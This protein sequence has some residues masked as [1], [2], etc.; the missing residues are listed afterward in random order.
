[1][2]IIKVFISISFAGICIL[3]FSTNSYSLQ[4]ENNW[5]SGSLYIQEQETKESKCALN[6]FEGLAAVDG[7]PAT[8]SYVGCEIPGD[9]FGF[10][11][12]GGIRRVDS[13]DIYQG[14]YAVKDTK[15]AYGW[16]YR[17][18]VLED[19][20]SLWTAEGGDVL[21]ETEYLADQD[22]TK[23]YVYT[24]LDN[25]LYPTLVTGGVYYEYGINRSA[26][27]TKMYEVDHKIS[28]LKV[29]PDAKYVLAKSYDLDTNFD[30]VVKIDTIHDVI[31]H[32][33]DKQ[34]SDVDAIT[35]D[36]RYV[37]L[38]Y[39]IYDTQKC[40]DSSTTQKIC[41]SRAIDE[42]V[43]A[44]YGAYIAFIDG[45]YAKFSEDGDSIELNASVVMPDY[46]GMG[47]L[48][49]LNVS[50]YKLLDYLA[51]GDSYSSGEG[52]TGKKANGSS[53]Y[54]S[55]FGLG[56]GCHV[57]SRSY[58]FLLK[59]AW[60]ISDS[61]MKS[62]ACSGARVLPDMYGN[63]SNYLGQRRELV[64]KS[65]GDRQYMT[66]AALEDGTP[67]I[68]QQVEF[69][70][71]YRP[72]VVT[73]T[74]GGNDV[75][76]SDVIKYCADGYKVGGKIPIDETCA[77]ARDY[78]M[79]SDLYA[80]IDDQY[81][82]NLNLVKAIKDASPKSKIYVIGYP[83]FVSSGLLCNASSVVLNL[84]ERLMINGSVE[85]MNNVLKHVAKDAG[86]IYVDIED[87]LA[88]G[89][90]CEGS[91]YMT[92]PIGSFVHTGE[93]ASS[94]VYHP[95][96]D[97]QRK[98]FET[99]KEAI[100]NPRGTQLKELGVGILSHKKIV[101]ENVAPP[102]V[103][104]KGVTMLSIPEG[105]FQKGSKVK[106]EMY[107]EVTLLGEYVSTDQSGP[108]SVEVVIP[109][110]VE[111]GYH[112]LAITGEG[113]NGTSYQIQQFIEVTEDSLFDQSRPEYVSEPKPLSGTE[114]RSR[115]TIS[116][117]SLDSQG[118]K[119]KLIV[120]NQPSSKELFDSSAT[121]NEDSHSFGNWDVHKVYKYALIVLMFA[122]IMLGWVYAKR[123]KTKDT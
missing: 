43:R 100:D 89:R 121:P 45:R 62:V 107:S 96:A 6:R 92:G 31:G 103:S 17:K 80:Y 50:T 36:G 42:V 105:I 85:R 86:I 104:K 15:F 5:I 48:K 78:D 9:R 94:N 3:F 95:N 49:T 47:Q 7:A 34:R 109:G 2:K 71:K 41:Q 63:A 4:A 64:G 102:V 52:D 57:S 51:L 23:I 19:N 24:D 122:L 21:V 69:V 14:V 116:S 18:I 37:L 46:L 74:G 113:D 44:H 67:G 91:R 76:F 28:S 26:P 16:Q 88:G 123:K 8:S 75:G 30:E 118:N 98:M 112:L 97:G 58:P 87:S 60:G 35:E 79:L 110:N 29:T 108:F 10:L 117:W 27:G 101:K 55:E 39:D 54:I 32:I 84:S 82:Y 73:L 53:Y 106:V 93:L 99:I 61:G 114:L 115:S 12:Q 1:M 56:G 83:Y 40:I 68:V 120:D 11:H 111:T 65:A 22:R 72:K 119:N 66:R 81:E 38:G 70:R 90:I 77:Y 33:V 59:D 20:Q 13:S 25:A